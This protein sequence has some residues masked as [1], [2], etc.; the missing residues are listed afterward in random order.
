MWGTPRP[1]LLHCSKIHDRLMKE[2][3]EGETSG[4]VAWGTHGDSGG[5]AALRGVHE[6][7]RFRAS[8][9]NTALGPM[10]APYASAL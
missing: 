8:D 6:G 9:T 2:L 1:A 10:T 3:L 5:S 7:A 4:W